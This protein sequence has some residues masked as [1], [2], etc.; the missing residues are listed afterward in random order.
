MPVI[1]TCK[2][3]HRSDQDLQDSHLLGAAIYKMMLATG[4]KNPHPL[5]GFKGKVR[6]SAE[7]IRQHAFCLECEKRLHENGEDWVFDNCYKERRGFPLRENLKKGKPV[8][9]GGRSTCYSASQ[10][11]SVDVAKLVYFGTSI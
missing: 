10:I 7:Q 9:E 3:C 11:P 6:K 1:G 8:L 5:S 4:H 2:L